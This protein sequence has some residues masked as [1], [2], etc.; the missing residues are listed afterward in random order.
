MTLRLLVLALLLANA[1]YA[2]WTRGALAAWGLAPAVQ[3]EPQR[4]ARQVR[5][6]ALRVAVLPAGAGD[7]AAPAAGGPPDGATA[8]GAAG[9]AGPGNIPEAGSPGAAEAAAAVSAPA[10]LQ[11]GLLDDAAADAVRARAEAALPAGG[12]QLERIALPARW[13]VY[14]GRYA[15][16]AQLNRKRAELR[17]RR[18]TFEPPSDPALEPGLSL[19]GFASQEAAQQALAGLGAQGVRTARVVQERPVREGRRL[20]LPAVTDAVR[21]QLPALAA[22]LGAQAL[23]ACD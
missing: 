12:W 15:D 19:G 14:M 1:G 6:E 10:C 21:A 11:T 16:A 8:D 2:A 7:A 18:V 5:P 17:A 3:A 22:A 4:L 20:R 9:A 23:R 13:I